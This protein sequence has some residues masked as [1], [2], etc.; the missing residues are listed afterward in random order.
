LIITTSFGWSS[1]PVYSW[2]CCACFVRWARCGAPVLAPLIRREWLKKW[3]G[4]LT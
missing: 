4:R 2:C 1:D 3:T